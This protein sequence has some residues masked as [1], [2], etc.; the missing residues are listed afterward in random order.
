[1]LGCGLE[2]VGGG[3]G[4]SGQ[5]V[6]AHTRPPLASFCW[7]SAGLVW[8]RVILRSTPACISYSLVGF[9][10]YVEK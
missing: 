3:G 9:I 1:M 2:R 6:L 8:R 10:L 5:R 7:C 4:A